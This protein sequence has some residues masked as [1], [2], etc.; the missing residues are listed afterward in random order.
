MKWG[1][2]RKRLN[3]L[4]GFPTFGNHSVIIRTDWSSLGSGNLRGTTSL[5]H[6]FV[7][8]FSS[9]ILLFQF[10]IFKPFPSILRLQ[11]FTFS[12]SPSILL[13]QFFIQKSEA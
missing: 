5:F 11:F 9:S 6:F 4:R 12:S 3:L 13:F 1:N 10:F 2:F 7:F 8:I